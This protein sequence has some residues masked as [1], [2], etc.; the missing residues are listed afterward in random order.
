MQDHMVRTLDELVCSGERFND[1]TGGACKFAL[2][3]SSGRQARKSF[4]DVGAGTGSVSVE[5][6]LM[7]GQ[8]DGVCD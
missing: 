8:A 3:Q 7:A 5:L 2:L 1:K 6:S 4:G